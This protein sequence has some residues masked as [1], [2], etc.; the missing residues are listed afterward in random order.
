MTTTPTLQKSKECDCFFL[1]YLP[2]STVYTKK[3]L[4]FFW[5]DS[6]FSLIYLYQ[7]CI[8]HECIYHHDVIYHEIMI[9]S[10][11]D[12]YQEKKMHLQYLLRATGFFASTSFRIWHGLVSQ[13]QFDHGYFVFFLLNLPYPVRIFVKLF[14]LTNINTCK[15]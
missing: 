14:L 9:M 5:F 13:S 8:C 3:T 10:I 1:W 11:I 6:F 7:I 15:Y 2:D 12:S 4:K